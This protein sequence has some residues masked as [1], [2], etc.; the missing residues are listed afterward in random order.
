MTIDPNLR[1]ELVKATTDILEGYFRYTLEL[2]IDHDIPA[3]AEEVV[4]FFQNAGFV[5]ATEDL[6]A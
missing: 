6:N 1:R 5:P 2:R 3:A 4:L